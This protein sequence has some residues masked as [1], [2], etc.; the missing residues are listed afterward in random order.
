MKEIT[1]NVERDG[2]S[3][4][5]TASWDAPRGQ[6]GI[7]TQG[8]DLRE[9]EQNVREAVSCHFGGKKTPGRIRLHF[10]DDPVLV[11]A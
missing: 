11:A 10:V 8:K 1:F 9:L 3:G 6:G 5:F 7:S 4:G 2:E